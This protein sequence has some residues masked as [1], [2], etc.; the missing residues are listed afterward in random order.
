MMIR[1]GRRP[2]VAGALPEA[3]AHRLAH[4]ALQLT[5]Q[6]EQL[7]L[8]L[9]AEAILGLGEAVLGAGGQL[10]VDVRSTVTMPGHWQRRGLAW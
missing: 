3:P 1:L 8:L 4:L 5:T 2:P 7:R 6:E 9:D 10:P